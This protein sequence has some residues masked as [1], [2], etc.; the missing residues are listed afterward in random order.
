MDEILGQS[1]NTYPR[2]SESMIQTIAR[3][4]DGHSLLVGGF[5]GQV[6]SKDD[7]KVPIL[8]DIPIIN[9]FFK[10]KEASKESSSLVFVVTPTSYNPAG[11]VGTCNTNLR[12]RDN[13]SLDSDHDWIDLAH[14]GRAHVPNMARTV[15]TMRP[16]TPVP[17]ASVESY[18]PVLEHCDPAPAKSP[19]RNYG[20]RKSYGK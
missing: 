17:R 3:V 4:P 13:L 14:P 18:Q 19:R 8:G 6:K 5:Y 2:V 1:G 16:G 7:N 9:F 15:D 20:P 10:S 12:V 11:G